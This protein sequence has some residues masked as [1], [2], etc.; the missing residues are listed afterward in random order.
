MFNQVLIPY[1]GNWLCHYCCI[2][3]ACSHLSFDAM[4]IMISNACSFTTFPNH[5]CIVYVCKYVCI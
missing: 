3:H 1:N 5:T 2:S 4:R